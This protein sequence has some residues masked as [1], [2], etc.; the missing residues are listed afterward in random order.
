MHIEDDD[1][2]NRRLLCRFWGPKDK[3]INPSTAHRLMK[4][5][6]ISSPDFHLGR[7]PMWFGRTVKA[8]RKAMIER[9][10]RR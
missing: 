10:G 2:L 1:H 5:G 7:T 4:A 3:P 6:V 8:D 9:G